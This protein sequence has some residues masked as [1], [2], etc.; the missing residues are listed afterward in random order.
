MQVER[1]F[2]QFGCVGSVKNSRDVRWYLLEESGVL[3]GVAGREEMLETLCRRGESAFLA[4]V[5]CEAWVSVAG[6]MSLD[7]IMARMNVAEAKVAVVCHGDA[8]HAGDVLGIIAG[9]EL[10]SVLK[11]TAE[12][13][14][15]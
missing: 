9:E 3:R 15:G 5:P 14:P 6:G 13:F 11:E 7:G 8:A 10:A 12:L 1:S 2:R 4:D